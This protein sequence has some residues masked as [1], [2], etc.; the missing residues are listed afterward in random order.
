MTKY[1]LSI[2]TFRIGMPIKFEFLNEDARMTF[3]QMFINYLSKNG[4]DL[5]YIINLSY[6]ERTFS[7]A[8][9]Q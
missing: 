7:A 1:T 8:K 5:D 3:I 4:N 6:G 9:I 2:T